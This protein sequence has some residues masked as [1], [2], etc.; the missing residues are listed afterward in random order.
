MHYTWDQYNIVYQLYFN[1][2]LFN[3]KMQV[4]KYV[5]NNM[6]VYIPTVL[7]KIC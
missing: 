1:K 3:F 4:K 6:D 7:R 2:K 5:I